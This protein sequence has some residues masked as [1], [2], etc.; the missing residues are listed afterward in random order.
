ME[1]RPPSAPSRT[2]VRRHDAAVLRHPL[3]PGGPRK[4][5]PTHIRITTMAAGRTPASMSVSGLLVEAAGRGVV[6]QT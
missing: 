6:A 3:R 5:N 2:T 4:T 1:A